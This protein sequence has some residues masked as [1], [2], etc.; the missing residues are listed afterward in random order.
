MQHANNIPEG[1]S[2][3]TYYTHSLTS[4]TSLSIRNVG[5]LWKRVSIHRDTSGTYPRRS[6]LPWITKNR[7]PRA[8]AIYADM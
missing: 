3:A 8:R 2:Q 1:A 6:R 5:F 7:C 4:F